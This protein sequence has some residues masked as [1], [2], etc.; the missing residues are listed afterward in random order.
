MVKVAS[1]KAYP[2]LAP[3]NKCRV[4][5]MVGMYGIV[6]LSSLSLHSR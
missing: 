5:G 2:L 3:K 4:G 6:P 1:R